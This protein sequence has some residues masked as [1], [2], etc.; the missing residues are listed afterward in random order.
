MTIVYPGTLDSFGNPAGTTLLADA[1]YLHNVQHSDANDAIEALET[2]VGLGVGTPTAN[3]ILVGSGNGTAIWGSVWTNGSLVNPNISGGTITNGTII[4]G[5][6]GTAVVISGVTKPFITVG[7]SNADYITDGTSDQVQIQ[8]AIDAVNTNGGGVVY[9][10]EGTYSIDPTDST[11]TQAASQLYPFYGLLMKDNV[12]L[13]GD[14]IG[15]TYLTTS[16]IPVGTIGSYF[17]MLTCSTA[18]VSNIS[19]EKMNMT[20]APFLGGTTGYY[21]IAFYFGGATNSYF[22]DL[23]LTNAGWRIEGKTYAFDGTTKEFTSD[24]NNIL[25]DNITH[26]GGLQTNF[27]YY[28]TNVK[29][30]NCNFYNWYDD[31]LGV[32]AAGQRIHI[33]NN[34]FDG[35]SGTAPGASTGAVYLL[36][37]RSISTDYKVVSDVK[38]DNNIIRKFS[39]TG[40]SAGIA[41]ADCDTIDITNNTI[42][43]CGRGI[44]NAG[45]F[46][47][48]NVKILGNTIRNN[49]QYGIYFVDSAQFNIKDVEIS[50]NSIYNNT[51]NAAVITTGR[52]GTLLSGLSMV[53]NKI[54]DD[55]GT[56]TQ[57]AGVQITASGA[58]VVANNILYVGNHTYSGTAVDVIQENTGG[59]VTNKK[60]KSNTG[61]ADN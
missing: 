56:I 36:N 17:V 59:T 51:G 6:I 45:G 61:I 58:S 34:V 10:K 21:D 54:Y 42:D 29:V 44:T 40:D 52:A 43:G 4:S 30:N 19:I 35:Q 27:I 7:Y 13:V 33:T 39:I 25:F 46:G 47:M 48:H 49:E 57:I 37:D 31:I 15:A 32:F 55:Q 16:D 18:P 14:G 2:K 60:I 38:L 26:D 22:R 12:H 11:N 28:A 3:N 9:L 8:A 53:G 41:I 1:S 23:Y 24:S 20:L 50:H 5:T